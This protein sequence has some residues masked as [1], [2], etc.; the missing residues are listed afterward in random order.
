MVNSS[1][2][3]A[4]PL[5]GLKDKDTN[6]PIVVNATYHNRPRRARRIS[7]RNGVRMCV[8]MH[9][10]NSRINAQSN[11]QRHDKNVRHIEAD[12]GDLADSKSKHNR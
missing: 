2:T 6:V 7:V 1:P 3:L 9:N 10:M 5:C 4:A 8:A 11:N 12:A